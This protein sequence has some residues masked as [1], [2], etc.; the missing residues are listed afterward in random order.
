M[1]AFKVGKQYSGFLVKESAILDDIH[2]TSYLFAHTQS[3]AR[4]FYVDNKDDN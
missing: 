2:S 4:L 3:G 1:A